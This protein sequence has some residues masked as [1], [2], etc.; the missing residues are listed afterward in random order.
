MP[1]TRGGSGR[2]LG[3]EVE[4]F[5]AAVKQ[6]RGTRELELAPALYTSSGRV[7]VAAAARARK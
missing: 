3:Q 7:K 1:R 5:S 6:S 4:I 2:S